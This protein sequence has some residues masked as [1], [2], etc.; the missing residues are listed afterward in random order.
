MTDTS[1]PDEVGDLRGRVGVGLGLVVAGG[2][3]AWAWLA[4]SGPTAPPPKE[5]LIPPGIAVTHPSFT[6]QTAD[7]PLDL[8]RL[9]EDEALVLYFGFLSCPD[10]CPTTLATANAAVSALRE[11]A[12]ERVNVVFVSVD[13]ERDTPEAIG[14]Y[15]AHFHEDFRGGTIPDVDALRQTAAAWG[16]GF[17]YVPVEGGLGYTVDHTTDAIVVFPGGEIVERMPHGTEMTEWVVMLSDAV[18]H[19]L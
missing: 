18:A 11:E 19:T 12:A 16:A 4:F 8:G 17:R 2:L 5:P 3:G 14:R 15:V 13:P 10:A 9:Y 7:G 1:I 6:I